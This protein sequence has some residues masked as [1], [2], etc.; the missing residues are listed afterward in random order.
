MQLTKQDLGKFKAIYKKHFNR[1]ITD[2]QAQEY[3]NNLVNIMKI[4]LSNPNRLWK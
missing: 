1:D 2:L 4:L 3:W